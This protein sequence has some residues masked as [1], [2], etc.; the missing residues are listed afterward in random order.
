MKENLSGFICQGRAFRP[1]ICV[2]VN[3]MTTT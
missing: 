1:M 2:M 3:D